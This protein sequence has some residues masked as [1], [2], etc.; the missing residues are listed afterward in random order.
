MTDPNV[1]PT[2]LVRCP[3]CRKSV[4]YDAANPCRPFCSPRCKD[5]DIIAWAQGDFKVPGEI[6]DPD[7]LPDD[8]ET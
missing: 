4:R 6:I 8:D 5:E 2:R 7:Q 3:R 1:P